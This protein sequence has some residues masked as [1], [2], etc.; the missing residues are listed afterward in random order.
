MM[1][2]CDCC[3]RVLTATPAAA[4]AGTDTYNVVH[5]DAS[6][7][8]FIYFALQVIFFVSADSFLH[9]VNSAIYLFI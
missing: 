5:V 7:V 2:V 3:G 4:P 1:V 9:P 8:S 6:K